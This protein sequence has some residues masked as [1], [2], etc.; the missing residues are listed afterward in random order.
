[1]RFLVRCAFWGLLALGAMHVVMAVS[2][3]GGQEMAR[4]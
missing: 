1:M 3:L 2:S 4:W